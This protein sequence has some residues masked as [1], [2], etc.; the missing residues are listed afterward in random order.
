MTLEVLLPRLRQLNL[1]GMR[2]SIAA[3]AE[4]ARA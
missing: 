2:D 1:S 4:E 3:R